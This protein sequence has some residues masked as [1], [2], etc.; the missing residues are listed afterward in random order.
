M[1]VP[2]LDL[3]GTPRARGRAQ[4]E[5]LRSQIDANI[6]LYADRFG[7]LGLSA[8]AIEDGALGWETPLARMEPGFMEEIRGV[9]EGAG[10]TLAEILMLNVRYELII[11]L[12]R[13]ARLASAAA[14]D[15]CTSFAALPE[16]SA[17]GTTWLGQTWDWLAGVQTA[18][19][20]VVRDD[21]P[22]FLCLGEAGTVGGMQGVNEHG[23]GVVI[24]AMM[25]EGDGSTGYHR[26]F[27]LRVRDVLNARDF[28]HAITAVNGT[29]R[30]SSMNF[31]I[32]A[33]GG[34]VMDIEVSA[35]HEAYIE[36]RDGVLSHANHFCALKVASDA[37][38]VWPSSLYRGS[39][40][41]RLMAQSQSLDATTLKSLMSD[42]FAYPHS[43]CVHVDPDAPDI[44]KV[45]TR[46]G[47]L[48]DLDRRVMYVTDGPPCC[49]PFEEFRLTA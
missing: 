8:K 46:N 11:R 4:G 1:A 30:S 31:I 3:N 29:D 42:H 26:P 7:K 43:I 20:R 23:I 40:L 47:V 33:T 28:S 15:G 49:A 5:G 45:E 27:R 22:D 25:A 18:V 12:F 48:I 41:G 24:N 38:R 13:E 16:R 2:F 44:R 35:T 37:P 9:A 39:R 34:E 10:R 19:T 14:V 17:T 36:P 21:G 6:A 32:G